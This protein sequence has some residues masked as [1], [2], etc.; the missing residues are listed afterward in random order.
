[1]GGR[2]ALGRA[3]PSA[4]DPSGRSPDGEDPADDRVQ[5][6]RDGRQLS[7]RRAL[8]RDVGERRERRATHPSRIGRSAGKHRDATGSG[9]L[10]ARIRRRRPVLLWWGR[11][12]EGAGHPPTQT[13]LRD[14]PRCGVPLEDSAEPCRRLT[15]APP[16]EFAGFGHRLRYELHASCTWPTARRRRMTC[17]VPAFGNGR[18]TTATYVS[19]ATRASRRLIRSHARRCHSRKTVQ[20]GSTKRR[21]RTHPA[22]TFWHTSPVAGFCTPENRISEPFECRARVP[23]SV[24]NPLI[25]NGRRPTIGASS[26][27]PCSPAET[28]RRLRRGTPPL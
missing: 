4:P 9:S 17:A 5:P 26:R 27:P 1:M 25:P 3:T 18:I 22:Y 8:A 20:L 19:P 14:A 10:R 28:P 2:H 15:R 11:G 16:L 12:R 7:R 13:T 23:R 21:R 24:E 6:L